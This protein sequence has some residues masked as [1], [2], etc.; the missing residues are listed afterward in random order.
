[1]GIPAVP[2]YLNKHLAGDQAPPG[3]RFGLFFPVWK[4]DWNLDKDNKKTALREVLAMGRPASETLRHIRG[5]Q[6]ATADALGPDTVR[7]FEAVSTAPFVT[8]VGMEHPVENGFAFLSPYGLPYLPGSSVKGVLRKAAEELTLMP[9]PADRKGWDMLTF[10]RFFGFEASAAS[11]GV[12]AGL[13]RDVAELTRM[14]EARTAAFRATAER[15]DTEA[16][17]VFMEQVTTAEQRRKH[18]CNTPG[19]FLSALIGDKK[20]RESISLMGALSFWDVFLEPAGDSLAV[21]I[22]NPHHGKY[23][24][25]GETPTDCESPV[26]NFFLVVPPKSRFVMYVQCEKGRLPTSLAATWQNM[27]TAAFT[28][29]FDWLG[30]GAKTAVGYGQMRRKDAQGMTAR[31]TGTAGEST[32]AGPPLPSPA[33]IVWEKAQ[34]G[35]NPG[36]QTLSA[37]YSGKKAEVKLGADRTMISEEVIARLKKGKN[38]MGKVTVESVGNAWK[39]VHV[40]I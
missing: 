4:Q 12:T 7:R 22:L 10:W 38:I 8:G 11:L 23:Y 37:A 40:D 36:T 31:S 21:D 16:V 1:M 39:I 28:H 14:A 26:P 25:E 27:L 13:P 19:A 3:H 29:A 20:L 2:S 6:Q 33:Q 9:D 17:R 18:D 32:V 24:Q 5:R 34:F 35:W 30:F 15:L